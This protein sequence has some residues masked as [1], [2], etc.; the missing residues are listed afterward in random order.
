MKCPLRKRIQKEKDYSNGFS[1]KKTSKNPYESSIKRS[2]SD[3]SSA[4][5]KVIAS[6]KTIR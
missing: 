1:M 5:H 2:S 6:L 4:R 3:V